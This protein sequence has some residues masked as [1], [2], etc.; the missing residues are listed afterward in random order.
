MA[1]DPWR[2][3]FRLPDDENRIAAEAPVKPYLD[4]VLRGPKN[5]RSLVQ[6]LHDAEML[7][8]RRRAR[9]FV[10]AFTVI[11]KDGCHLRLVLDCR[12]ANVLHRPPPVSQLATAPSLA[13]LVLRDGGAFARQRAEAGR[14]L[15]VHVSGAD[16][17]DGYF[18]FEFEEAAGYFCL[19]H[20]VLA[21]ECGVT[22]VFDDDARQWTDVNPEETLWTCVKVIP[23]GWTWSFF[24]CRSALADVQVCAEMRRAGDERDDVDESYEALLAELHRRG[25]LWRG[26]ICAGQ[27][28]VQVGLRL[29][30]GAFPM[31]LHEREVTWRL[32]CAIHAA[33]R[34]KTFS[35]RQF[36]RLI[37]HLVNHFM[38]FPPF[39]S[40]LHEV[41]RW[42][43][44]HL[45]AVGDLAPNVVGELQVAAGL[46]VI[47]R[48]A[49]RLRAATA[50][51]CSDSSGKGYALHVGPFA[52]YEVL[53][54]TACRERWRFKT[55]EEYLLDEETVEPTGI[56]SSV[57]AETSFL[58]PAFEKELGFEEV[59]AAELT[60]TAWRAG[61]SRVASRRAVEA[62]ET[63]A[64]AEPAG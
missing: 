31:M 15:G 41:W 54:A 33:I 19:A 21:S 24:F 49:M 8:F 23:M 30:G 39:I 62:V 40:A 32:Y 36:R 29:V 12:P 11:K 45:D 51:Y 58:A 61:T 9:C 42:L 16:L 18:Q 56:H 63:H 55:L 25:F 52:E 7:S 38:V 48:R 28:V 44:E 6:T 2:W 22:R 14:P 47:A 64:L 3:I 53:R 35:A 59:G 37:G 17:T 10:G 43:G 26:D 46:V 13:G 50:V 20:K 5:M 1:A 27:D 57:G 34:R 60:S 4:P